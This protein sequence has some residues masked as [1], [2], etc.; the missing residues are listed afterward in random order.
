[1]AAE[2]TTD[3]VRESAKRIY[4]WYRVDSKCE[5]V[6]PGDFDLLHDIAK[7]VYDADAR[8]CLDADS[9]EEAAERMYEAMR[10]KFERSPPGPPWAD[11]AEDSPPKRH[12]RARAAAARAA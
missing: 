7:N 8:L 3:R 9:D 1:M 6:L 5:D 2:L 4:A 12:Y 10:A 11:V